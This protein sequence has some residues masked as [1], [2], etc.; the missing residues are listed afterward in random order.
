MED[1]RGAD[2]RGG[3]RLPHQLQDHARAGGGR[4]RTVAPQSAR[5]TDRGTKHLLRDRPLWLAVMAISYFWFL[6]LLFQ[7]DLVL[8][9]SETLH[10]TTGTWGS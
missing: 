7:M 1:R 6:A 10:A 3:H 9:G 2:H 4:T 8:F 5:R